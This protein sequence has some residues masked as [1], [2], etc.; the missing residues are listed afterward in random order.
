MDVHHSRAEC[1][2]R[3]GDISK[4]HG[5][6]LKAV[7]LWETAKP[8]FERSSQ[9]KQLDNLRERLANVGGDVVEQ[10]QQNLAHLAQLN[11]PSGTGEELDNKLSDIDEREELDLNE[12]EGVDPAADP[13]A[14]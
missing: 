12:V 11:A 13:A 3:L 14:V 6:L 7:E 9:V 5:E 10:H 2:L 4:G 8:L 1:M